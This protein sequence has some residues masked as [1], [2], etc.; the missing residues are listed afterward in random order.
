M[1]S[2]ITSHQAA[3]AEEAL[4]RFA[5]AARSKHED[6]LADDLEAVV[7]ALAGKTHIEVVDLIGRA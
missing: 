4:R 3:L 7:R 5:S 6:G 1:D 2:I